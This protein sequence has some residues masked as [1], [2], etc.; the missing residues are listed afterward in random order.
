MKNYLIK[1]HEIEQMQGTEKEH[2][3]NPNALRTNKSLGDLTGLTG[4]GFHIIEVEPGRETTEYHVHYHEDECVYVLSGTATAYIGDEEYQ[5]NEGDFIGYRAGGE[6]HGITNTGT[7]T[8]KCIVVGQRLAFDMADY[9][10]KDKRIFREDG[11][12]WQLV[13]KENIETPTGPVGKK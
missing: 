3:L 4:L 12:P 7:E 1:K 6:A 5:I 10:H 9:P 8:L 13:D 2:F 11:K